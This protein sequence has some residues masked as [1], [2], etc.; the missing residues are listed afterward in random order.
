MRAM[1]RVEGIFAG[2]SSG[3]SISAALRL[4]AEVENA[5]IVAIVCDR[6]DRYLSTGVF[7][8]KAASTDPQPCNVEEYPSAIRRLETGFPEPHYVLFTADRDPNTHRPWCPDCDRALDGVWRQV[9]Q[10][11]G[12]LLEVEVGPR[13][14]WKSSDHPFRHDKQLHLSGIP[15]LIHWTA[16]GPGDRLDSQLESATTSEQAEQLVADFVAATKGSQHSHGA[17]GASAGHSS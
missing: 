7:S 13:P 8:E 14:V 4:S 6:G 2:V 10:Q 5:T 9:Q 15:T 11:N 1:A 3:G 17:N 12:T 16:D